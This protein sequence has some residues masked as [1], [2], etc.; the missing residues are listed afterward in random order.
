MCA[1]VCYIGFGGALKSYKSLTNEFTVILEYYN[2]RS[3]LDN[4]KVLK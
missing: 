2:D 1:Y 4:I 3:N